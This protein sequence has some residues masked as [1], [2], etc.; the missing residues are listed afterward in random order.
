MKYLKNALNLFKFLIFPD[1][2]LKCFSSDEYDEEMDHINN[3]VCEYQVVCYD[4]GTIKNFWA[5]GS[6]EIPTDLD[7][8]NRLEYCQQQ[9]IYEV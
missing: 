2:C 5:Y 1:R 7:F 6:F 3:I 8:W 4:C 9:L